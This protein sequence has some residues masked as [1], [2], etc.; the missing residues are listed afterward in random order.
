[1]Q[2]PKV[3][4]YLALRGLNR[5]AKLPRIRNVS[6]VMSATPEQLAQA[7]ELIATRYPQDAPLLRLA[8]AYY[9]LSPAE[10]RGANWTATSLAFVAGRA[11]E[12]QEILLGRSVVPSNS[13]LNQTCQISHPNDETAMAEEFD[14]SGARELVSRLLTQEESERLEF[15][16]TLRWDIGKQC[17][18]KEISEEIVKTVSAFLNSHGGI[19]L[20]GVSDRKGIVGLELDQFE[21][22]D[23]CVQF[24]AHLVKN[25]IG[26]EFTPYLRSY[27]VRI[28]GK[29]VLVVHC[30]RA[31]KCAVVGDDTVYARIGNTSHKLN[32]RELVEFIEH[33]KAA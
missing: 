20:V 29:V 15:K 24:F 14:E 25:R 9:G 6:A 19:L 3:A 12:A 30:S 23:L 27:L 8:S 28:E 11:T 18:S 13:Q 31:A 1:M 10:K 33:R 4:L 22:D 26:P 32:M 21:N 16:S 5:G 17:K 7:R 2:Y